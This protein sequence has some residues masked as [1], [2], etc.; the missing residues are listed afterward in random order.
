[1]PCDNQ[2]LFLCVF[3]GMCGMASQNPVQSSTPLGSEER[4]KLNERT[5]GGG[6]PSENESPPRHAPRPQAKAQIIPTHGFDRCTIDSLLLRRCRL[7]RSE[8]YELLFLLPTVLVLLERSN[9]YQAATDFFALSESHQQQSS[10]H[11]G[12][13]AG[14]HALS[15]SMPFER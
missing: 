12:A 6:R 15:F 10:L 13:R 2:D 1:M 8:E 7:R 9:A 4:A 5:G 3:F 11:N 14:S